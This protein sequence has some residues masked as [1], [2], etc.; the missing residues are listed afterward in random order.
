MW[1]YL[2]GAA[3]ALLLAG[4]GMLWWKSTAIAER[5]GARAAL[6]AGA[7]EVVTA[8]DP[9]PDPP[10]AT[11]KTKEQR[12]FNRYDHD[13]DG[14]ISRDEYL[15]MRHKNFAKLDKNG[16]GVLSFDE[17]AVKAEDK[18]AEADADRN[19]SLDAKEF[20]TTRVVRKTKPKANCP[21]TRDEGGKGADDEG[22]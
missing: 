22:S 10:A 3:A 9:L 5:A 20:A 21:P 14:K 17:Y 7:G 16:D 8:E 1:R 15:A 2:V 4:G 18:F 12:R 19:G 11:E 6:A 13:K